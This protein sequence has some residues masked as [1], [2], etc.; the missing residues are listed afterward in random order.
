MSRR[1]I[2]ASAQKLQALQA[3]RLDGYLCVALVLDGKTFAADTLVSA[4]GITATGEKVCLGFVQTGTENATTCGAFL[5][6]LGERGLRYEQG[7]LC[8]IDG[9]KGLRKAVAQVFGAAGV[10]QRCRW[11]KRENVVAYLPPTQQGAWRRKL[12]AAYAQPT[13]EGAKAAL[14]RVRKD[15]QLVN[16][17]AVESLD[18]GLEET[19]TL[20]RLEC[21][22]PLGASLKTTNCLESIHAQVE[23]RTAMVDHWRT[24]DQK[25]RWMAAALLDIEPRLRRI[26]GYH[27]LPLL[28]RAL[29]AEV[30]RM[31]QGPAAQAAA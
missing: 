29:A 24:S 19:L 23:Q 4:L 31:P 28:Q 17:S 25:Q 9:A 13:Y 18:E 8:V 6:Q 26:K 2:R 21:A 7:L 11:H 22:A 27:H 1:F 15:L 14:A 20:H 16:R 10:V 30:Q 5:R 12:Q 3:R